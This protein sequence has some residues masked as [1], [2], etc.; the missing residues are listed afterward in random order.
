MLCWGFLDFQISDFLV[1]RWRCF[2]SQNLRC[3]DIEGDPCCWWCWWCLCCWCHQCCWHCKHCWYFVSSK[4]KKSTN[5]YNFRLLGTGQETLI[6]RVNYV[7]AKNHDV[8]R[9]EFYISKQDVS[10]CFCFTLMYVFREWFFQVP[11]WTINDVQKNV[12]QFKKYN[13]LVELHHN[14][15]NHCTFQT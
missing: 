13:W 2:R 8:D 10:G 7:I 9:N 15:P 14:S 12:Y 3:L 11:W 6:G 1:F 4:T 5:L